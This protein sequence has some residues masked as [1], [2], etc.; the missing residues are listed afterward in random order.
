MDST[1]ST[2]SWFLLKFLNGL[3]GFSTINCQVLRRGNNEPSNV[4]NNYC[5]IPISD[6]FASLL[7]QVIAK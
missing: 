7:E 5:L 3:S 4:L 6:L 2:F 1:N